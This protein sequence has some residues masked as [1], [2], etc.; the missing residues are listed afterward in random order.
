VRSV[1]ALAG[2]VR[3]GSRTCR[4]D[5]AVSEVLADHASDLGRLDVACRV[6][7]APAART[8]RADPVQLR[9]LLRNLV[10]NAIDALRDVDARPRRLTLRT[11]A[12]ADGGIVVTVRDNGTGL[13]AAAAAQ[14]FDPL[15]TTKAHGLGLGLAICR[16]IVDA[17]GGRI[18]LAANPDHGCTAGFALP[19]APG[20]HS[21]NA[22]TEAVH[23]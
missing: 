4:L 13:D 14:A 8:V 22:T 3:Q 5:D 11:R 16:A 9:Q 20:A 12:G 1:C 7:L 19:A 2:P 15:A 17:H 6:V 23:G 21:G 18:W 10:G